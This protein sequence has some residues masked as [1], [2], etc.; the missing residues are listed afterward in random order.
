[1]PWS[2]KRPESFNS[3]GCLSSGAL[4][5]GALVTASLCMSVSMWLIHCAWLDGLART[6]LY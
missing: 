4:P 5:I 3:P 6:R 2:L 1:M